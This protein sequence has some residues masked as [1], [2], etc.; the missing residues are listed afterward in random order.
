MRR[1][2]YKAQHPHPSFGGSLN[3]TNEHR[4]AVFVLPV[5]QD[6]SNRLFPLH[7]HWPHAPVCRHREAPPSQDLLI[8]CPSSASTGIP[9]LQGRKRKPCGGEIRQAPWLES[10]GAELELEASVP[11]APFQNDTA[12]A[13]LFPE[14]EPF[15]TVGFR[16]PR[17][18][19]LAHWLTL[20]TC[21]L[22]GLVSSEKLEAAA[23]GDRPSLSPSRDREGK[24]SKAWGP[25]GGRALWGR[26]G[27]R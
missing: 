15:P 9:I 27:A 4:W 5:C 23:R 21:S 18:Q 7:Q 6:S 10:R 2:F 17:Q 19:C 13:S 24:E 8:S 26:E 12:S 20:C 22:P 16:P 3:P 11:R 1:S 25:G 14:L